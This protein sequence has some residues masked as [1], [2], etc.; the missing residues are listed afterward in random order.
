MSNFK[1]HPST[2]IN[3]V[4]CT[5]CILV[6]IFFLIY[7][8]HDS[9]TRTDQEIDRVKSRIEEQKIFYPVYKDLLNQIGKKIPKGIFA[10]N[11]E[12]AVQYDSNNITLLIQKIAT[13]NNLE[14]ISIIYDVG[15]LIDDSGDM[16]INASASGQFQDFRNFLIG[17]GRISCLS[18]MEEIE[19]KEFE[20]SRNLLLG[21]KI[22]FPGK[23]GGKGGAV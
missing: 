13:D 16:L 8:V 19:I 11:S 9:I 6:F 10:E 23:P 15:S 18:S 1:I 7:P 21:L 4:I 20:N 14:V 5:G 2:L 3:L 12:K 22:R 17:L